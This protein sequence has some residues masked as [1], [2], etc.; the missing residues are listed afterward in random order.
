MNKLANNIFSTSQ[1][2][3]QSDTTYFPSDINALRDFLINCNENSI[4][5]YPISRGYNWGLGASEPVDKSCRVINL[6][7][8][9]D[10]HEL[11]LEE[12]FV[13]IGPGVTQGEL[14]DLLI[15]TE[16]M[17][18]V[19]G[20]SRDTSI[21]GNALERGITYKGLRVESVIGLEVMLPNGE[22]IHTG[23]TRFNEWKVKNHYQ[24]GVGADLTS[25]FFQSNFG[26]VTKMT[27][28]LTR[29]KK[30]QVYIKLNF[31]NEEKL[32]ESMSSFNNLIKYDI[33]DSVY[34]IANSQRAVNAMLP[35]I[36]RNENVSKKNIQRL[37]KIA[38]SSEWT[39]SGILTADDKTVLKYKIK[40]LRKSLSSYARVEVLTQTKLSF[41]QKLVKSFGL[42]SFYAFIKCIRSLMNLYNGQSTNIALGAVLT[43]D[44]Y[45][46][47][48]NLS[49]QVEKSSRGFSYCLPLTKLNQESAEEMVK[50][51]KAIC[52]TYELDPSITL[53]PI[54][55]M[56]L[57]AVVS[58]EYDKSQFTKAHNCIRELQKT[59]NHQGHISYRTNIND[60][61]LYLEKGPYMDVLRSI[62]DSFDPNAIISPGRYLPE[63]SS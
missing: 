42:S 40:K 59:L 53:N 24:H 1:E 30:Y 51:I 6:R 11:N 34:H 2:N 18:D 48:K 10:I 55:Y 32:F 43:N 29:K 23:S 17:I 26:V 39:S 38:L 7:K 54:S 45:K 57:E 25:L 52:Q 35:E 27:Y 19:T 15:D 14:S 9:N 16:Y 37:L 63:K 44:E 8:L 46:E 31:H 62:K 50:T 61:D 22:I 41:L 3:L 33:I 28:R 49:E 21:I 20:S 60:M 12:G 4:K 47:S 13:S 36:Y 56:V 5:V 58:V